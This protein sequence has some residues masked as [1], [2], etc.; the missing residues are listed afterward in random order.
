MRLVK[1]GDVVKEVKVNIDRTNNP[2]DF[3]VAGDHMEDLRSPGY[4]N[5]GRYF[6]A[7]EGPI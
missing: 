4:L 7:P 3:Y 5:L 1:F 2:Y 6:M